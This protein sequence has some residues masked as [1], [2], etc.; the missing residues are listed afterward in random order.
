MLSAHC[1][2]NALAAKQGVIL[3]QSNHCIACLPQNAEICATAG[4]GSLLARQRRCHLTAEQ[5]GHE[6]SAGPA[7]HGKAL[8]LGWVVTELWELKCAW[9]LGAHSERLTTTKTDRC[10]IAAL[11]QCAAC[12]S[13][14]NP[15]QPPPS[16]SARGSRCA[17]AA[18]A[19]LLAPLPDPLELDLQHRKR[20]GTPPLLST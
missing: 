2:H 19:G 6:M 15:A 3:S 13:P 4:P 10:R 14:S 17:A 20:A 12:S 5:W 11:V 16:G 18:A 1:P 9:R 8:H 7:G